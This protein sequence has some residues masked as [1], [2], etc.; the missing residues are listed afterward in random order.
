MKP[1]SPCLIVD[2][3]I[4]LSTVL[5]RPALQK[6]KAVSTQRI[7]V[8]TSDSLTEIERVATHVLSTKVERA[9]L[10]DAL[11]LLVVIEHEDYRGGLAIAAQFLRNAPPSRNGSMEDAH[12]LACAWIF[13]ADI[14]SHDRDF[15]GTG[16]PNW[17]TA[18]LMAALQD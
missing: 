16:W 6:L 5:G 11:A 7:L 2:S 13:N 4:I 8:V 12:I 9:A 10:Q 3:N 1:P 17:S 15:A 18:N 14:W